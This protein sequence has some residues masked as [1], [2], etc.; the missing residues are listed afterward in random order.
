MLIAK[1]FASERTKS[2][3]KWYLFYFNK[4][5]KL[6]LADILTCLSLQ[7]YLTFLS[8]QSSKATPDQST[9]VPLAFIC[10]KYHS[11]FKPTV[12]TGCSRAITCLWQWYYYKM[13]QFVVATDDILWEPSGK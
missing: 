7:S 10:R 1:L 8:E 12:S 11:R 4:L 5:K 2:I 13:L 6:P 9:A 3:S